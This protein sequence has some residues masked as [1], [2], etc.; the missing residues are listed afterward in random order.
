MKTRKDSPMMKLLWDRGQPVYADELEGKWRVEWWFKRHYKEITG[1]RGINV[2]RLFWRDW[3][4]LK[5]SITAVSNTKLLIK[6]KVLQL[7]YWK[8]GIIDELRWVVIYDAQGNAVK[9][10]II[11][12]LY[13]RGKFRGY[14]WMTR[15]IDD[16]EE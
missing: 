1:G 15:V 3:R 8:Y 9:I 14:F 13:W 11:G 10:G 6:N 2:I 4:V 16:G 12:R 7:Y 5:F